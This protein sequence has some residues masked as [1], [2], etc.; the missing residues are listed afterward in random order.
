MGRR[1]KARSTIFFILNYNYIKFTPYLLPNLSMLY[2]C[3]M[4]D[5]CGC[6]GKPEEQETT[7]DRDDAVGRGKRERQAV[8]RQVR[9]RRALVLKRMAATYG[10][11]P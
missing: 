9:Q 11:S 3:G 1:I 6:L 4:K 8:L 7:L 5:G 10:R 2:T